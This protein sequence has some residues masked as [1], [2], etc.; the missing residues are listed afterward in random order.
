M[1]C[2]SGE[3]YRAIMALLF[4]ILIFFGMYKSNLFLICIVVLYI[5]FLLEEK[6]RL[7]YQLALIA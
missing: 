4:F 5:F 2:C 1:L 6:G 7:Q 3:R